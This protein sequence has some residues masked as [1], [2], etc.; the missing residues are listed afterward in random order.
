[1]ACVLIEAVAVQGNQRGLVPDLL[2]PALLADADQ[3]RQVCVAGIE[4]AAG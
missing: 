1:M 2:V 4:W 3:R